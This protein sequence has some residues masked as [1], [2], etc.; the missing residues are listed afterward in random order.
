MKIRCS[1]CGK[2]VNVGSGFVWTHRLRNSEKDE[3]GNY[4]GWNCNW[5]ADRIES[6]EDLY[7]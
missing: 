2:V 3:K 5:C 6:G 1:T 4:L 7:N